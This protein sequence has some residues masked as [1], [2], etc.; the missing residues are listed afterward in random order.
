MTVS[1]LTTGE[2]ID[3]A[4]ALYRGCDSVRRAVLL[5][6][7]ESN[8][9]HAKKQGNFIAF[10]EE[11]LS[12]TEGERTIKEMLAWARVERNLFGGGNPAS[13]F[14]YI[15]MITDTPRTITQK[16]FRQL[17]KLPEPELQRQAYEEVNAVNEFEGGRKSGADVLRDL[18]NVV[19][20]L[21]PAPPPADDSSSVVSVEELI[22]PDSPLPL[23]VA[24]VAPVPAVAA[25]VTAPVAPV[26]YVN[27]DNEAIW[28]DFENALATA[29]TWAENRHIDGKK[30]DRDF[31]CGALAKVITWIKQTN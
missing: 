22:L 15:Q 21:T 10:C 6:L 12:M 5:F 7:F 18:G 13:G 11:T 24:P 26:R 30:I 1:S 27:E 28:D 19:K 31:V 23:T 9:H 16:A 3:K 2:Q 4:I 25:P 29:L 17:A 20:R 8:A 14:D